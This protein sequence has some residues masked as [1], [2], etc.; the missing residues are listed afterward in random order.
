GE[1][2]GEKA[3]L[4]GLK[5]VDVIIKG[6]GGGRESALRAFSGKGIDVSSIKDQTP[7]AFNGPRHKKP[8]RV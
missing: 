5:D 3:I 2:L 6:V 4:L 7:V 1:L 8:R